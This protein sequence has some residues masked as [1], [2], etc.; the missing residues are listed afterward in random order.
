MGAAT[1]AAAMLASSSRAAGTAR[2]NLSSWLAPG[3]TQPPY[4]PATPASIAGQVYVQE[5]PSRFTADVD[6]QL[7]FG[8]GIAYRAS[9]VLHE[10]VLRSAARATS[11]RDAAVIW[12]PLYTGFVGRRRILNGQSKLDE[13]DAALQHLPHWTTRQ[14]DHIIVVEMDR[15]RCFQSD[16]N[17]R[18][19]FGEATVLMY[20]GTASYGKLFDGTGRGAKAV[21]SRPKTCCYCRRDVV[22]PPLVS[23]G[24]HMA[25]APPP[26]LADAFS[27][28][29]P[30]RSFW[31]RRRLLASF[32]GDPNQSDWRR[33]NVRRLLLQHFAGAAT[34]AAKMDGTTPH[35][36][37]ISTVGAGKRGSISHAEYLSE[38]LD[39]VFCLCPV[40]WAHWSPR[41]Y[42]A[43]QT[44]C[45][46]VL[47]P[48][49]EAGGGNELPFA[50]LVDYA[51][52]VV[53]VPPSRVASLQADL[54]AIAADR[55]E[56]RRRQR[57]LWR[58]RPMLDWTDIGTGGAF[59]TLWSEVSASN[60]WF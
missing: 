19:R 9:R 2:W 50:R 60:A 27:S 31:E 3:V 21:P 52:F 54:H 25:Q 55:V 45:V 41:F 26:A 49:E 57:A 22:I 29:W 18:D 16:L 43:I 51:S 24:R 59:H 17:V 48:S 39:S 11:A 1:R 12:V 42:E 32:R 40:G 37:R 10:F 7:R 47:F 33:P 23:V 30:R 46:P 5:L 15:G 14:A 53:S 28:K 13:V 38:L 36:L 20:D 35:E 34:A 56:L 8:S 44:G 58:H 6:V 4:V